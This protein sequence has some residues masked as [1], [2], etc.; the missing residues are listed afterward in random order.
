MKNP[1]DSKR[2]L[3]PEGFEFPTNT[4]RF[5][6]HY[7]VPKATAKVYRGTWIAENA[8]EIR[9]NLTI[10]AADVTP[11]KERVLNFRLTKPK[12]DWPQGLYRLEIRADGKLVHTVR[13]FVRDPA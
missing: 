2:T 7:P 13:F 1:Q 9:P 12:S 5:V 4:P 3:T 11:G 8:E 10:A 6:Y